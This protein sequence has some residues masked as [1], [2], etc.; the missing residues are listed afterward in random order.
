MVHKITNLGNTIN[1]ELNP[2]VHARS[3]SLEILQNA[4]ILLKT[5]N[6]QPKDFKFIIKVKDTAASLMCGNAELKHSVYEPTSC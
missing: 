1:Q 5:L 3:S 6:C 4:A 2:G